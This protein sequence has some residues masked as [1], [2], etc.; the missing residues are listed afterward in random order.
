MI[1]SGTEQNN[2][3]TNDT[4]VWLINI[5]E[6]RCVGLSFRTVYLLLT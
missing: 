6:R 3:E 5:A 4:T 1:S 2:H